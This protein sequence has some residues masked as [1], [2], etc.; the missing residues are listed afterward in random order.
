MSRKNTV[1]KLYNSYLNKINKRIELNKK[2]NNKYTS[3]PDNVFLLGNN[4]YDINKSR[5]KKSH[6]L[7]K[8]KRVTRKNK[9]KFH[10]R[11]GNFMGNLINGYNDLTHNIQEIPP[12][13]GVLPWQDNFSG[14]PMKV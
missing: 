4:C 14:S 3:N 1:K 7:K 6:K 13:K 2:C 8:T 9:R 5:N 12:A 10:H 11:G